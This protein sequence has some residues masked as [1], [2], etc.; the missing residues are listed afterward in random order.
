MS[1]SPHAQTDAAGAGH[2]GRDGIATWT[3]NRRMMA[4]RPRPFAVYAVFHML[5]FIGQLAPGLIEKAVFDR[6]TGAATVALGLWA[7]VALYASVE[8]ARLATTFGTIW[9]D[10]TF[11]YITAGLL[12]RNILAAALRRPGAVAAPIAPGDAVS[13]LRDDV[14]EVADFPTWFPNVA[15]QVVAAAVAIAIMARI[16]LTITLFVFIPLT[17]GAVV[18]RLAWARIHRYAHAGRVAASAVTAFLGEAFGAV[19]AV[20]IAAAED[21][22]AA[23]LRVLN[24]TRRRAALRARV[25]SELLSAVSDTSVALGVGVTILLAGRAMAA[26]TFTVGDFALFV[27]YLW[28][29]TD[30]PSLL[31]AFVG[32]YK[33]QQVSIERLVE[34]VR[35]GPASALVEHHP[36]YERGAYPDLPRPKRRDSDRLERLDVRGLGYRYPGSDNGITGINLSLPRGS[37]TVVTGRVGA[38]KTT[39]LRAVLGLLPP[40]EGTVC[41]NGAPVGASADAATAFFRPPRAAYTAQAPR[42]FSETLRDNILMGLPD[43]D[44]RED[45]V[46]LPA[47]IRL[48]V[49]DED[50]A[51][52]ERG[53][54]TLV[55]PRGVRLSGGQAQRA[56]AAR[57]YV[58]APELL[59]FD[60]LSS[61]LDVETER[62]LWER[63]FARRRDGV[64]CLVV[65]HRRAA[66]ERA[67]HIVVLKDGRID[68]QGR[69][70]DLLSSSAE[71]RHLWDGDLDDGSAH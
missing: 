10:V 31:G 9:G 12:R 39:L 30:L 52:L 41:W 43:D 71:M 33:Q 60:D 64:T 1:A 15:G 6:L 61:A 26:H 62:A 63:L 46:D 40:A 65:S 58:R 51:R 13:R 29:T 57:M 4:Y 34:L 54:D 27:Y 5:F 38:G 25:F 50:V 59:V 7:L 48:G 24:E 42:L 19:Q 44:D 36:V 69:L 18:T 22:V 45:G 21:D 32:D 20:K 37:F 23:H 28:F 47:A 70:A 68:A 35:P 14:E 55:G 2:K 3:F 16:D 8:L 17:G 56:A 49:L 67:G 53:L 11:Q 66:L